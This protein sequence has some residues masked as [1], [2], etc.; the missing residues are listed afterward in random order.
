MGRR[1]VWGGLLG[2][3][4]AGPAL[5]VFKCVGSDGRVTY[6]DGSCPA[7]SRVQAV[8]VQPPLSPR[9]EAEARRRGERLLDDARAL[10]ARRNAEAAERQRS[11]EAEEKRAEAARQRESVKEDVEHWRAVYPAPI[12]G[13]QW[14]P[15]KPVLPKPKPVQKEAPARMNAYPFR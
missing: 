2:I 4:L 1:R 9:E 14:P 10:D 6:T 5:A 3:V 12:Y 8:E 11:L 13:R 7:D 15:V